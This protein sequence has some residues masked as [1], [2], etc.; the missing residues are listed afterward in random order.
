MHTLKHF[1]LKIK[2]NFKRFFN[3]PRKFLG[4]FLYFIFVSLLNVFSGKNENLPH[5]G[6]NHCML[7]RVTINEVLLKRILSDFDKKKEMYL[8]DKSF[9][10][11]VQKYNM[12]YLKDVTHAWG[13]DRSFYKD[14]FD[15]NFGNTIK[16][17][18]GNFNYRIENIWLY[19]TLNH[20]QSKTENI[21]SKFHID[22]DPSG[23]LK[24]IVYLCE[25]DKNNGPFEY[26]EEKTKKKISV[27]GNI[28]TTIIFNPNKLM[29]SGSATLNKE[30]IALSFLV[31][32]TVRK[33]ITYLKNKPANVFF[34]YN[35]LT[36]YS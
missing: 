21:N 16:R 12:D 2:K 6:V 11:Y 3:A 25:V 4:H 26:L 23:A 27:H 18:F 30:R 17:I 5:L 20:N 19:K 31:F 13:F 22:N 33:N 8:L 24:I 29:H 9:R 28:G 32:P 35:P 15:K 14:F 1:L 7:D 10:Y 36:K 34:T